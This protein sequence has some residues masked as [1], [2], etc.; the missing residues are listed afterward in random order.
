M[1]HFQQ[2]KIHCHNIASNPFEHVV[3]P[4][5]QL[6]C[7]LTRMLWMDGLV[8]C[9][10]NLRWEQRGLM[11]ASG[12]NGLES[13]KHGHE[14]FEIDAHVNILASTTVSRGPIEGMDKVGDA[15]HDQMGA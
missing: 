15:Q 10:L 8:E 2:N 1:L 5:L 9:L 7:A 14:A 3:L 12:R 13:G 6:T 11:H 4:R